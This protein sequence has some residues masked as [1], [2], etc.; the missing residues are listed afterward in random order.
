MDRYTAMTRPIT[1]LLKDN[2][3][4]CWN[5]ECDCGFIQVKDALASKPILHN[6][7]WSKEFYINS[8]FDTHTLASIFHHQED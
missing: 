5:E 7:D 6:P 1:F 2:I 8:G 4:F 3:D